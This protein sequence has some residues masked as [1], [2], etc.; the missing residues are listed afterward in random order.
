MSLESAIADLVSAST[1]LVSAVNV[2]RTTIEDTGAAAAAQVQPTAAS[3]TEAQTQA[4]AA[5]TSASTVSSKLTTAAA[6]YAAQK[7]TKGLAAVQTAADTELKD[8]LHRRDPARYPF[9]GAVPSLVM[10]FVRREC[11]RANSAGDLEQVD[12][13]TFMTF[14][15]SSTATYT[16]PDG[17]LKTAAINQPRYDYDPVTGE[18]KGLLVEEQRTNLITNSDLRPSNVV[19]QY[20]RA[21]P[22]D[23]VSIQ[24]LTNLGGG[25]KLVESVSAGTWHNAYF[26]PSAIIGVTYT[27]SAY[28]KSGTRS[29]IGLFVNGRV[30]T[31][32]IFDLVTLTAT[33]IATDPIVGFGCQAAG[34]GWVRC[35]ITFEAT[36]ESPSLGISLH[37]DTTSA[38]YNGDGVS[39][40]YFACLQL[41]AGAFPTSYTPTPATFT[42]RT[43]T[44]TYLDSNG[45]LQ[46]A[47]S[48]V[49][50]SN[51]Y[52]YDSDGVLRPIGL[53][54]EGSATNLVLNSGTL[55]SFTPIATTK[56]TST[57]LAPDNVSYAQKITESLDTVATAHL[58]SHSPGASLSTRYTGSAYLKAG[59]RTKACINMHLG[60]GNAA[61]YFDLVAGT[62]IAASG[63]AV[64]RITKAN[65]GFFRCEVTT[66]TAATG[67]PNIAIFP[68]N[69]A[70]AQSYIGDGVSGI[71]AWGVQYAAGAYATSYIPTT[72]A[73]VTRAAD[74]STSAQVTR[75]A[76]SGSISNTNWYH[77]ETGTLVGTASTFSN[78]PVQNPCVAS[79][80]SGLSNCI[81]LALASAAT[82]Y[83][84]IGRLVVGGVSILENETSADITTGANSISSVRYGSSVSA[85]Y[86]MGGT[87]I[88]NSATYPVVPTTQMILGMGSAR[89]R[90]CGY[91]KQLTY[92]P[93]ALSDADLQALTILED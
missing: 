44:A 35:W 74:T 55:T 10:D 68:L 82:T 54:L 93:R 38:A 51:A 20:A 27:Y 60:E 29:K 64:V 53:L 45:V 19:V 61:G 71:Y 84:S 48:G 17:L 11:H 70:G 4:S 72:S 15:R 32:V 73:Q 62:V 88:K 65:N 46:T 75:A 7:V 34:N 26:T 58:I 28:A 37:S 42:G 41:E 87:L 23:V 49:A 5:A 85:G 40:A 77:R 6:D 14:T 52:G 1:G 66:T 56:T 25:I 18:C 67:T 24:G 2:T 36:N 86:G 89:G 57:Q 91:I 22:T 79:I 80:E 90:L 9:R 43:S 81:Q 76:D 13:S 50:R 63:G 83:R 16:G 69:D 8:R 3:A 33:S 47:A 12:L 78:L 39:Y 92:F 30:Q 59:E 21:Y 31:T